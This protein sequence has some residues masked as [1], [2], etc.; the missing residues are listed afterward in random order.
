MSTA[1]LSEG[2]DK[3]TELSEAQKA[4]DKVQAK[5]DARDKIQSDYKIIFEKMDKGDQDRLKAIKAA[6][7]PRNTTSG[8][9]VPKIGKT[10]IMKV[11]KENQNGLTYSEVER[12]CLAAK[13]GAATDK[14]KTQLEMHATQ[15]DEKWYAKTA[16]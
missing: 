10:V 15:T 8:P 6:M 11:L 4:L 16:E 2:V 13:P 5:I 1:T 9:K 7:F 12:M 14:I 3:L